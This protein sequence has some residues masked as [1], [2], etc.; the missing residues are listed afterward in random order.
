[1]S[2][3][4]RLGP[5][6]VCFLVGSLALV[7]VSCTS[8]RSSTST[9]FDDVDSLYDEGIERLNLGDPRGAMAPFEE[10]AKLAPTREYRSDIEYQLGRCHLSVGDF[11]SAITHF[12]I[13]RDSS[14]RPQHLFRVWKGLGDAWYLSGDYRQ[15]GSAFQECLRLEQ[16]PLLVDE[17]HYKLAVSLWMTGDEAT[18]GVH[19]SRVR[20]YRP[21]TGEPDF[22]RIASAGGQ[23][24]V[25]PRDRPSIETGSMRAVLTRRDWGARPTRSNHDPMTPIYRITVHHSAQYCDLTSRASVAEHIHQIQNHHMRPESEGGR[26]WADIGYHFVVDRVGRVWEGRPIRMQG[27]HAGNSVLNRGNV[28]IVLLG[29][30][31]EQRVTP[32]QESALRSLVASLMET[33][34][35]RGDRIYTHRELRTTEC[36][37][38]DLQR[39]VDRVRREAR[40]GSVET[41]SVAGRRAA[42]HSVRRGDT[43]Y[44]IARHYGVS[45]S[46]LRRANSDV[47]PG[48]LVSGQT[49][50]IPSR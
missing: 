38:A 36:P 23:R 39:V 50:V 29:D 4:N 1:M 8:M 15:A 46:D 2:Q 47:S 9:S 16:D 35:I 49:L 22:D 27:A 45:V 34:R 11:A 37:G 5:A 41:G 3:R 28:G 21:A 14:R 6:A 44:G 19:R 26:D 24:G 43:L 32:E 25:E 31:N 7:T 13:A 40:S 10:A 30:F 17:V 48:D 12:G 20:A 42:R 33:Y 18:A